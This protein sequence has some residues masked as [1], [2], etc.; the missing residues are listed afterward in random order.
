MTENILL[1]GGGNMT[2]AILTGLIQA[3]YAP[4]HLAV[5][6]RNQNKRDFFREK[7]AIPVFAS[8]SDYSLRADIILLAVKPQ[9]FDTLREP[10]TTY[11]TAQSPLIVSVMAGITLSRL[12]AS[13]GK[14]LPIVR[15]MPNV[16]S[17]IQLGATGLFA[18]PEVSRL[19]KKQVECLLQ[20]IGI[21]AWLNEETELDVITPLFGAGPAYYFY[22]MEIMQN[23]AIK[24]GIS[25]EIARQFSVQTAYGAAKMAVESPDH[26]ATLRGSVTSAKGTT[27]AALEVFDAKALATIFEEAI[28]AGRA[29]SIALS[30]EC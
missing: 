1:I 21:T 18:N 23:I 11:L 2:R 26:L 15:A 4:K 20:T 13:L 9:S 28:L 30:A 17:S 25:P 7:Y 12:N 8:L 14:T 19:Q 27:A 6:D 24:L 16:C 29:R 22:I 3:G 10:L 5:I